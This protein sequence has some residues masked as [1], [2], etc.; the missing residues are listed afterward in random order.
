MGRL[1]NQFVGLVEESTRRLHTTFDQPER[2]I[3]SLQL[4]GEAYAS[5]CAIFWLRHIGGIE[6]VPLGDGGLT[7]CNADPILTWKLHE[8]LA[9]GGYVSSREG[10]LKE[11]FDRLRLWAPYTGVRGYD[12]P[13][14]RTTVGMT[15]SDRIWLTREFGSLVRT[16]GITLWHECTPILDRFI[17][18]DVLQPLD[19][20]LQIIHPRARGRIRSSFGIFSMRFMQSE[21]TAS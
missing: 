13:P 12:T 11:D 2:R 8:L 21:H 10:G 18:P 7:I 14:G 17:H 19:G 1:A 9:S 4:Y 20:P 15:I 5:L 6:N 3:L 16:L